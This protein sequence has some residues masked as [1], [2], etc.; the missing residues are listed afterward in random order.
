[1]SRRISASKSTRRDGIFTAANAIFKLNIPVV[2]QLPVNNSQ[3]GNIVFNK[4]DNGFYGFVAGEWEIISNG[5]IEE[6]LELLELEQAA[7]SATVNG[8]RENQQ[9]LTNTQNTITQS[10]AA[11][12]VNTRNILSQLQNT[13]INLQNEFASYRNAI[14]NL[15]SETPITRSLIL[16][17]KPDV[18]SV[19]RYS[20]PEIKIVQESLFVIETTSVD[21]TR[22]TPNLLTSGNTFFL[23]YDTDETMTEFRTETQI[24]PSSL[25]LPVTIGVYSGT[26]ADWEALPVDASE[27]SLIDAGALSDIANLSPIIATGR[28]TGSILDA[29]GIAQVGDQ[30]LD[31]TLYNDD[32]NI[33]QTLVQYGIMV[34]NAA[35]AAAKV[36]A[37]R[38][39]DFSWNGV[40]YETNLFSS[41]LTNLQLA[42]D[43]TDLI[44]EVLTENAANPPFYGDSL[45]LQGPIDTQSWMGYSFA[46]IYKGGTG[47]ESIDG[48][49]TPNYPEPPPPFIQLEVPPSL[50]NVVQYSNQWT[51]DTGFESFVDFTFLEWQSNARWRT[52]S[53]NRVINWDDSYL[54]QRWGDSSIPGFVTF[55]TVVTFAR[56]G[57]TLD[58][59]RISDTNYVGIG[60]YPYAF[61]D[62]FASP[63]PASWLERQAEIENY[64][65]N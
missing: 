62:E 48:F 45:Q 47:S 46:E 60:G 65:F 29:T 36:P 39:D 38:L 28:R 14:Q 5:E 50:T 42:Y 15:I 57:V 16:K 26:R 9:I 25:I 37:I 43:S 33:L 7:I 1:M 58:G 4:T 63:G 18:L 3:L 52:S 64:G 24:I 22:L 30:E 17:A 54:G 6:Q 44:T 51:L 40:N 20:V 19:V 31:V 59:Q 41:V 55:D 12:G 49:K 61:Y 32:S 35:L 8:V 27:Q 10:I 23:P 21:W 2:N 11:Q 53:T 56:G 34:V 13:V